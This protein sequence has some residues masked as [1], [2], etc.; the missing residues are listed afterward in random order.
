MDESWKKIDCWLS[1]QLIKMLEYTILNG[2][3]LDLYCGMASGCD[4]KFGLIASTLLISDVHIHF[5]LPCKNYNYT[6]GILSE[7]ELEE[8][9][10]CPKT[11]FVSLA[12]VFSISIEKVTL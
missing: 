12:R 3:S 9:Y 10:R 11:C 8:K 4:I 1:Q 6:E 7:D 5:V 2:E